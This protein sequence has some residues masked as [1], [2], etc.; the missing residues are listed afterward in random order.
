MDR[1]RVPR[2]LPCFPHCP[3]RPYLILCPRAYA[4]TLSLP[5]PPCACHFHVLCHDLSI[6]SDPLLPMASCSALPRSDAHERKSDGT[7]NFSREA[8]GTGLGQPVDGL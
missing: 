6:L 3:A 1:T 5:P 7:T 2:L 8:L 4:H